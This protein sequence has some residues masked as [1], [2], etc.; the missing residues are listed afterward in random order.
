METIQ[1]RYTRLHP[2]SAK[3][4]QQAAGVFPNGVTHDTR[5]YGPFTIYVDHAQ[6][7]KKWDVDGNQYVDYVMGH[8]ALLLGHARPEVVAAVQ[9]Q[10]AKGT[11]YG[12][13]HELELQWA[14]LVRQLIPSAERVRFTSS[15]TEATLMSLR[16]ARAYTRKTKIIKFDGH[17]H[18]WHDYVAVGA[19]ASAGALSASGIPAAIADTMIVLPANDPGAVEQ[20]L[21]N[22]KDVAG[23]ILEPTGA[24]MGTVPVYP[25]FLGELR[26]LS[27]KYG[28]VLIFDEVVTGFRASPGGAQARYGVTPDVTTLA[29]ILAGGLPGG[30]VAGRADILHMI[31][32]GGDDWNASRRVPHPGTFNANPLSASAG[33]TGLTL[34]AT[35]KENAKADAMAQRLRDG[36]NQVLDRLGVSGCAN[37]VA[38]M[39]HIRLGRECGAQD[40]TCDRSICKLAP[41]EIRAG[42]TSALQDALKLGMLN[43]GVDLMSRN[44]IVSSAHTEHDINYTISAF[45]ET[46]NEMLAEGLLSRR[47]GGK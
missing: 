11:H 34:V 9:A 16:L 27:R 5:H 41:A 19:V 6:G 42:M 24:N 15:G 47:G 8:G 35:G 28:V 45:A 17:F 22:D 43:H 40:G 3:L 39:C 1:E 26:E 23:I 36:L 12:A 13:N 30:A 32:F 46:V 44:A 38:S 21:A 20:A 33:V 14:G 18:G 7:S 4:F 2:T 31:E 25:S 37:G 10:M 29:K